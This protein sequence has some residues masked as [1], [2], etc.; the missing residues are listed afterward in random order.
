ME[1]T[2]G[3]QEICDNLALYNLIEKQ[4]SVGVDKLYSMKN[5]EIVCGTLKKVLN[6][7][8]NIYGYFGKLNKK[9]PA[10]TILIPEKNVVFIEELIE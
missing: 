3:N 8:I 5:T 2:T 7:Y 6:G 1:T 4:V 10:K 9:K